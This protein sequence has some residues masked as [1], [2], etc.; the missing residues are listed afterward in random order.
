MCID[1]MD[2]EGEW[3]PQ[4]SRAILP[5]SLLDEGLLY[6]ETGRRRRK[7]LLDLDPPPRFDLVIV[8][9][10]HHI[11]NPETFAHRAVR[12][13]CDNAEAVLFM[14]A[15]PLQMGD[16]DLFVLLNALRPDLVI[17]RPSYAE[18]A[19]PNPA[20]NR[21]VRAARGASPDWQQEA[22]T[23]LGE[24][25]AT[26]WGKAVFPSDP[27]YGRALAILQGEA[28][29]DRQRVEAI[30]ALEGLHSFAGVINRTRRRDIGEFTIRRPETVVVDFTPG[31]RQLHD[32]LLAVQAEILGRLHGDRCVGFMMTTL[33]RQAASCI[34][35]LAPMIEDL[36][37][38]RLD[39]LDG[40]DSEFAQDLTEGAKQALGTAIVSVVQEAQA[41]PPEDP[42][43][44]A[45]LAVLRGR[46]SAENRRAMVFSTFRH[47]LAYLERHLRAAGLRVGLVHGGVADQDRVSL[48][49]R[50][51]MAAGEPGAIDVLLFSEVGCEGLD[52]QFCDTLVNYDLPWNPMRIEQRI[53]RLDR[54]GQRSAA[55]LIYNLIT[56]GTVDADIYYRCLDRIGVFRNSVG[57]CEEILGD[58]TREVRA[59]AENVRLTEAERQARL[60]QIADNAIR[61][62]HEQLALEQN[63]REFFGVDLSE[64]RFREDIEAA[65]SYWLSPRAVENL[66]GRYLRSLTGTDTP[67]IL[68]TRDI[69]SLRLPQSV[70]SELLRDLDALG[71]PATEAVRRWR[72]W[73]KGD[74]AHSRVTFEA[75]SAADA[76]DVELLSP[77]HPLVQQAARKLVAGEGGCHTALV[78]PHP[79][80]PP[81]THLFAVYEWRYEGVRREVLFTPV[82]RDPALCAILTEALAQATTWAIPSDEFPPKDTFDALES[83]HYSLWS[84]ARDRHREE[85]RALA[86]HRLRSLQTSHEARTRLLQEQLHQATDDKIRRMRQAQLTAATADY[87]RRRKETLTGAERAD[88]HAE[89]VAWGV[90]KGDPHD[91]V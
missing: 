43:L 35:G 56:P 29:D 12:F 51:M 53:G 54:N 18:M 39:D 47:T 59:T 65:S 8:D 78:T 21:A 9:E 6:G 31:Q 89:P 36:L 76:P 34:F 91:A 10:A 66:L 86:E 74:E 38:R 37:T 79:G 11:R 72:Q 25:A 24:A 81:G 67:A 27:A 77:V 33:K 30:S 19:E 46:Q 63:Q 60:Q 15:T 41:L 22:L 5:Y 4:Y 16:D 62:Q 80:V 88:I 26:P 50:F 48:R 64:Q 61:L 42:K 23:A 13:L 2:L 84:E 44:D 32:H 28:P 49:R 82:C 57:D 7:G 75:S 71:L 83:R 69:R 58:L 45:L 20:V 68:G 87:E 17:D 90:L 40:D 85:T 73:L 55:V 52:Y 14:T 3:D 70:R 1:E